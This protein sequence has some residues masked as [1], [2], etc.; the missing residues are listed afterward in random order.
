MVDNESNKGSISSGVAVTLVWTDG[1]DT[2]VGV[3]KDITG[4]VGD[5]A[6]RMLWTSLSSCIV[7]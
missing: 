7:K 6:G 3:W 5:E 2:F 1:N 4:W